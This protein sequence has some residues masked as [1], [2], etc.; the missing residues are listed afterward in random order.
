MN[1]II[2]KQYFP[3]SFILSIFIVF[4]FTLC[5]ITDH[6]H[7]SSQRSYMVSS[8]MLLFETIHENLFPPNQHTILLGVSGFSALNIYLMVLLIGIKPILL[9]NDFNNN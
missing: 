1:K 3:F 8:Y 6:P 2:K 5:N 9:Q 7:L 4:A